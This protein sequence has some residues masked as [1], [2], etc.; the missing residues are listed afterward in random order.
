M[1][2]RTDIAVLRNDFPLIVGAGAPV[3]LDSAAT[4]QKPNAVLDALRN[5]YV[6]D[7]ANVHRAAHALADRA[8]TAFE[9]ARKTVQTFVNA[10]HAHEIIWTR[11]TTESINLVAQSYAATRLGAG[12]EILIS[13]L[14]HHSNIV[15]WQLVAAK[16]GA[17]VH[18]IDIDERGDLDLE[19][20]ARKLSSRTKIVAVGHVSNA[21]GT[22]NPVK[23]IVG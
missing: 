8:T 3:Y 17:T 1:K 14:E 18:T 12:D 2:R 10:K 22:I 15:P 21:L 6:H 23:A 4:T 9:N 20:F 5:Y 11:G 16:T 13:V 7:N 19:D